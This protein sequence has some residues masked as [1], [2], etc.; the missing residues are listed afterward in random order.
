MNQPHSI[1]L[2]KSNV[3]KKYTKNNK[4]VSDV[5]F[6]VEKGEFVCILGH[7]GSGKSTLAKLIVGLLKAKSGD[8][9]IN[10]TKLTEETVDKV[11]PDLGNYPIINQALMEIAETNPMT[12]FVS[13]EGLTS[14]PDNL[15]F[16]SKSLRLLG[17]RYFDAYL[18]LYNIEKE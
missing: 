5:S 7:N 4:A 1:L 10:G 8:I 14:N 16:N 9:I 11:R 12:G 2:L 15:H 6:T 3:K 13:A 17:K 18:N